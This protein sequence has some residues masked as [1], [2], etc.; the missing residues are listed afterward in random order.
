M[1]AA[2]RGADAIELDGSATTNIDVGGEQKNSTTQFKSSFSAPNRFRHSAD[3][4]LVVGS[5][6][7]KVFV[8][9]PATKEY[10][11]D[12]SPRERGVAGLPAL[13]PELLQAQNPS[14]LFALLGDP[15]GEFSSVFGKIAKAP[16]TRID[17][18]AHPTLTLTPGQGQGDVTIVLDPK[19][20][21]VKQFSIDLKPMFG[22]RGATDVKTAE[23][24]IDYS[25]IDPAATFADDSF[26][27]IPPEGARDVA[28][29]SQST[30]SDTEKALVGKSAPAF[31]LTSI[32]GKTVSLADLKGQVVV[33]DF[34]ASWCPPCVESL[35]HMGKLYEQKRDDG[36]KIF[37]INL[38]ED[39]AAIEGFLKSKKVDIP[40]LMDTDGSVA[41]KY[42][43]TS[44]PQTV[45]IGKDGTVKSVS[46]GFGKGTLEKVRKAIESANT[47]S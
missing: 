26:A 46:L 30:E 32:E 18:Q 5:T 10:L 25:Q 41:M 1:G 3:D 39:K 16:D 38:A 42:N 15:T 43:A 36:V 9:N 19:T 47:E 45:V 8:F 35:P 6:G 14:L 13:I 37:A 29:A 44:I 11:M 17:G 33:L 31:Q 2:Y 21:L 27:W 24:I 22:Q 28:A 34:W 23:V 4:S 12:A 20:H 40:V 7:E